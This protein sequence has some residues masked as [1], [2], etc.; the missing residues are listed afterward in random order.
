MYEVDAFES[1]LR[2]RMPPDAILSHD[3]LEGSYARCCFV[4]DVELFEEY[5]PHTEVA[6]ARNHRWARGDWQL[7][8]WIFGRR[9]G[10]LSPVARFKM[11]DNLR[12]TL[13]APS[14]FLL[15]GAAWVIEGVH[16]QRFALLALLTFLLPALLS[17]VDRLLPRPNTDRGNW[18]RMLRDDALSGAGRTLFQLAM[19]PRDALMML[20]VIVRT[21]GRLAVRRHLLEWNSAAQVQAE[22][23]MSIGSFVRNMDA[24]LAI[25]AATLLVVVLANPNALVIAAP[26]FALWF[27]APL[28]AWRASLPAAEDEVEPPTVAEVAELRLI[29]RQTWQFFADLAGP[30][31]HHLPPDNLQED[32]V[33][34]VAHRTSPTNIGMY[35]LSTVAAHEFGWIGLPELCDRIDGCLDTLAK[36]PRHRGHFYN[37]TDTTTLRSLEPRYV[38]TVDSGNLAGCLIALAS[39]ARMAL[40]QPAINGNAIVGVAD[41]VALLRQMIARADRKR[42]S[43]TVDFA[44]LQEA[45]AT[46]E[47]LLAAAAQSPARLPWPELERLAADVL[48]MSRVLAEEGDHPTLSDVATSAASLHDGIAKRQSEFMRLAPWSV[49]LA[50]DTKDDHEPLQDAAAIEYLAQATDADVPLAGLPARCAALR[51]RLASFDPVDD[52][53]RIAGDDLLRRV[54]RDATVLIERLSRIAREAHALFAEMDFRFLY[55][56]ARK[57]F[58][59]GYQVEHGRLDPSYYDLLASEARLASFIAIAK[60]DVPPEH[61]FRLGRTLIAVGGKTM[62]VS[63]SGSMF[64]YLMPSLLMDTPYGSLL[65]H[66][67]RM[68]VERQIAYGRQR[69][70][71]W[72]ISESAFNERDVHLTFQYSTFGV[73]GLGLKRGLGEDLVI[74][75]YATGLAAMYAPHEAAKNFARIEALGGR[76]RYGFYEALDFTRQR[77]PETRSVALVRAYMAHHQGMTLVSL[78][79]ALLGAAVRRRFQREPLIRASRACL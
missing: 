6:A 11:L 41:D 68:V 34:V 19:L 60:H 18:L 37:W 7:L 75:P 8:P 76:G 48:D 50:R 66:T 15:L 45:I 55:D 17:L 52:A 69:G 39:A 57:L 14:L 46:I 36:M 4:S 49:A 56:P 9:S 43:T 26:F 47:A 35:L 1:S 54:E 12:R 79:N 65:D 30:D 61:W 58:S 53:V 10:D 25:T 24:A 32:P 77:V 23:S 74:A 73:P 59:I 5:P 29:A 51:H 27:A 38:S 67:C 21:L 63:W 33:P 44:Q 22:A 2:G 40:A 42:P 16:A 71:P 70:V 72:G 20:D 28:L 3:L 62:L 31:D 78:A 64:E 13:V